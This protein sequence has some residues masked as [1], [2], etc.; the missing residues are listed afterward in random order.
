M[1]HIELVWKKIKVYEYTFLCLVFARSYGQKRVLWGHSDRDHWPPKYN[2]FI[3]ET[4]WMLVTSLKNIPHGIPEISRS[5]EWDRWTNWLSQAWTHNELHTLSNLQRPLT[6][7]ASFIHVA[8][9]LKKGHRFHH[10][11]CFCAHSHVKCVTATN[12]YL[13]V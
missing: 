10:H 12:P 6:F 5:S 4:N 7:R 2:Q 13:L 11:N 9:Q 1:F 3:F 8:V